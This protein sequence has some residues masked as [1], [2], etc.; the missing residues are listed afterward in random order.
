M[1]AEDMT[2]IESDDQSVTTTVGLVEVDDLLDLGMAL[3]RGDDDQARDLVAEILAQGDEIELALLVG[4]LDLDHAAVERLDP[5]RGPRQT[6][7]VMGIDH[8]PS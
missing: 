7:S 5:D 1:T 3:G 8:A 4:G 2:P 6:A